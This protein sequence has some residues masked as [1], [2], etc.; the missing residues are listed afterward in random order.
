MDVVFHPGPASLLAATEG[1]L[2][3]E[4]FSANVI[5]TVALRHVDGEMPEGANLW[6]TVQDAGEVVGMAMH[7]PP[8]HLAVSRM[9]AAAVAALADALADA[10]RDLNGVN[11]EIRT[12]TAFAARWQQRTGRSSKREKA[13]RLYVLGRLAPPPGIAGEAVLATDIAPV[14][15]WVGAFHDE[16]GPGAPAEDWNAWA[17]WRVGA[18]EIHLWRV[19]GRFVSMAGAGPPAAGVARIGP[20]YT[21]PKERRHGYAT[22]LSAAASSA[23]LAGGARHVALYTDLANPTSNAIYQSIGYRPD[24]DA[25]E[26]SF[27]DASQSAD[28]MTLE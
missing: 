4:P 13:M 10:C 22:A 9:P 12:T 6:A 2:R 16:A 18:G 28:L 3:R 15:E 5:A 23:A 21:P 19:D 20:V 17:R 8:W 26:R 24:H 7:T 27:L 11:G 14:A 1:F 25:E